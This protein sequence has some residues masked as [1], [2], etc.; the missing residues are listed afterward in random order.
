MGLGVFFGIMPFMGP[1]AALFF[2]FILKAN[3]AAALLGSMLTNTWLSIPAFLLAARSGS[4][5]MGVSHKDIY[6]AWNDMVRNFRWNGLLELSI[7]RIALP[8]IIGYLVVSFMIG[9]SVYVIT[10]IV[11]KYFKKRSI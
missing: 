6:R 2:A 10:L 3:R 7:Y 4:F 11:L 1:L 5:V 9:L 8:V